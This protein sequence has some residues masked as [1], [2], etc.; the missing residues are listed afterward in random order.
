MRRGRRA[1][2][3]SE[4]RVGDEGSPG[5]KGAG[6]S[7]LLIGLAAGLAATPH[8]LGMCGGFA[9]HI[10]KGVPPPCALVRGFAFLLGKAFS[11]AFLGALV[12]AFGLWLVRSGWLP[13]ARHVLAYAAGA[14]TVLLGVLMLEVMPP[15]PW[16]RVDWPG[17]GF[18]Q[19]QSANLMRTPS[20]V[21]HFVFGLAV[22]YL[23]CPLTAMLL[24]AAAGEHSVRAGILLL[25]GAGVGT[26]P[27][28]AAISL[29]GSAVTGRWRRIGTRLL[30]ILVILL[31]CALIL[32]RAGVLP[33]GHMGGH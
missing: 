33:G 20:L 7:Y 5:A 27:G 32:R 12:G 18:A 14:V 8:C 1:P 28:L 21:S 15:F 22:G 24:V 2:L 16:P 9:L 3:L 23:P 17:A 13:G 6:L 26:M 30:G 19:Q 29:A 4:V 10:G 25:A 11:Y 31:G